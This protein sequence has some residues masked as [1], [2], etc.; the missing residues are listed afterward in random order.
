MKNCPKYFS[1]DC[2]SMKQPRPSNK[3]THLS[4]IMVTS[5]SRKNIHEFLQAGSRCSKIVNIVATFVIKLYQILQIRQSNFN[6]QSW[7]IQI[8]TTVNI[9]KMKN[10]STRVNKLKPSSRLG[11]L[12]CFCST[13]FHCSQQHYSARHCHCQLNKNT[14]Y[15]ILF[16]HFEVKILN[17]KELNT[18]MNFIDSK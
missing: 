17:K 12:T 15:F 18:H 8:W 5:I 11:W 7:L 4:C 13:V 3:K 10:P 16:S 2:N 14:F 9:F 6:Q 1:Q